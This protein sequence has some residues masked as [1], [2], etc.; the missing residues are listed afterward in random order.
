MPII[1]PVL[2]VAMLL[3]AI[4]GHV[5]RR[6]LEAAPATVRGRRG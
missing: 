2:L 6:S 5:R 4:A 1:S 3:A